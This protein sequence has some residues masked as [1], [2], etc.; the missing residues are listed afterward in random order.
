VNL[1]VWTI[2]NWQWC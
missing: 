2:R 1:E